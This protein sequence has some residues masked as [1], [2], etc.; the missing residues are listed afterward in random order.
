MHEFRNHREKSDPTLERQGHFHSVIPAVIGWLDSLCKERCDVQI[1]HLLRKMFSKNPA[2][3]PEAEQVWKSLTTSTS[4]TGKHFCGPCCMPLLYTDPMLAQDQ[5]SDLSTTH[6]ASSPTVVETLGNTLATMQD[7]FFKKIF[8][9]N[10]QLDYIWVRNVRHW[11]YA[12]L[13]FVKGP[14]PNLLA[15]KRIAGANRDGWALANNEA[16]ILR[17][18]KHRHIVTLFDTY[19]QGDIYGLLY[20]PA[21]TCDLRTYLEMTELYNKSNCTLD[22]PLHEGLLDQSFGC[23]ASAIASVHAAGFDHGDIGPRN[24]LVHDGRVF[25]SK[26]SSGLKTDRGGWA[27]NQSTT[28][29][30]T[31]LLG[32]VNPRRRSFQS[33]GNEHQ[34]RPGG[35]LMVGS[36]NSSHY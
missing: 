17:Q 22:L 4:S 15:R 31:D 27:L 8:D 23:L 26:F 28:Y 24:I 18:V 5:H 6:Y 14:S 30:F 34:I 1:V 13:D 32:N 35:V 11:R 21:A 20:Q 33:A 19:Q 16:E 12:I 29:R 7:L 10:Q 36:F 2:Q 3:R 25:L 9:P